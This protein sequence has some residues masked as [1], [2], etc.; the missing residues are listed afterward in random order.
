MYY[1]AFFCFLVCVVPRKTHRVNPRISGLRA[2]CPVL[3]IIDSIFLCSLRLPF[4]FTQLN[5]V[6][7]LF[8][9]KKKNNNLDLYIWDIIMYKIIWDSP[10]VFWVASIRINNN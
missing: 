7:L 5:K 9:A 2:G 3:F 4:D 10:K 8:N 6:G 1:V